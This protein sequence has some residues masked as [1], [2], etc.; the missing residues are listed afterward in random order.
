[1]ATQPEAKLSA[2]IV[3]A[4]NKIPGCRAEKRLGTAMGIN[5]LD[6]QGSIHGHAFE[7]ETKMPG[8]EPTPRQFSRMRML[9]EYNVITGWMTDVE[10]A[11]KIVVDGYAE[12]A[13][14]QQ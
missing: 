1:M 9:E 7:I 10:T 8:K 11:I 5:T 14:K 3:A 12:K 4:L 6:I 2:K 13:T